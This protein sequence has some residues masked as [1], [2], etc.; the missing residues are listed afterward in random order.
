[1]TRCCSGFS[2]GLKSLFT[3]SQPSVPLYTSRTLYLIIASSKGL[4]HS[5]QFFPWNWYIYLTRVKC[6]REGW[7]PADSS[8][9]LRERLR[10]RLHPNESFYKPNQMI[11]PRYFTGINRAYRFR[12]WKSSYASINATLWVIEDSFLF[13]SRN[14]FLFI[15]FTHY[16][17]DLIDNRRQTNQALFIIS[18]CHLIN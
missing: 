5:R 1:M 10:S 17:D 4:S 12:S 2:R 9:R 16:S 7:K 8:C 3:A 14:F 6:A 18:S 13:I 15:S 11:V